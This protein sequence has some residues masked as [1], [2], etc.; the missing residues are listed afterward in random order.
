MTMDY[1]HC[2][3]NVINR[4]TVLKPR[5]VL[6]YNLVIQNLGHILQHVTTTSFNFLMLKKEL[7]VKMWYDRQY[8]RDMN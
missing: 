5:N 1:F 4:A 7:L 8:E 6:F 2:S 3:D